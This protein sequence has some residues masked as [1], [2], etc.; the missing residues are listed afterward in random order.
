MPDGQMIQSEEPTAWI[1]ARLLKDLKD[2]DGNQRDP[3]GGSVSPDFI[4]LVLGP[5]SVPET[6]RKV[7]TA[8]LNHDGYW[9][10][11]VSNPL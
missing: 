8:E 10:L 11:K 7:L 6:N 9:K 3:E 2:D 5:G 1:S 4:R